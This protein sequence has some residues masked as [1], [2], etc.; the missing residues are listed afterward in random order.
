MSRFWI[1]A[2]DRAGARILETD[3]RAGPVTE[4]SKLD[5]P[6]GRLKEGDFDSDSPGHAPGNGGNN[7][8]PMSHENARK[9]KDARDWARDIATHLEQALRK[10][11]FEELYLLCDPGF[12][13][14][15]RTVLPDGVRKVLKGEVSKDVTHQSPE[16]I[17]KQLPELL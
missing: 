11:R 13:G 16:Q 1:V 5:H 2:A 8:H 15:L 7:Q 14:T 12:L 10:K 9:E 17:R 3:K 4:V 6:D